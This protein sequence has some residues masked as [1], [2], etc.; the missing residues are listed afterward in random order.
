VA[1][2]SKGKTFG[3]EVDGLVELGKKLE[4]METETAV[5]VL[6]NSLR[7][8]MRPAVNAAREQA[9]VG[10]EAHRLH[11]TYGGSI[12]APGFGRRAIRLVTFKSKGKDSGSGVA[13]AILG[14]RRAAF[15]LV[16]F[17]KYPPYGIT[18]RRDWLGESFKQSAPEVATRFRK[19][20]ATRIIKA[21]KKP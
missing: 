20:L 8:A 12:V 3:I 18:G 17:W 7:T 2:K 21:A 5:K 6:R 16:Q 1:L 10:T 19:A 14:V 4:R 15:Y 11:R 9:P 13:A